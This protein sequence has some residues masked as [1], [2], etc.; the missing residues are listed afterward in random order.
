MIID[1]SEP[2]PLPAEEAFLLVRDGLPTLVPYLYDIEKIEVIERT[3]TDGKV[4]LV[5][6]WQGNNNKV[7]GPVRKFISKDLLCWKDHA[8]WTNAERKANWRIVPSVAGNVFLCTGT[9]QLV[10]D[11]AASRLIMHMDLQ[12]HPERVPGVPKFLARKFHSQIEQA[13]AKQ[14]TPNLRNLANSIR[15]YVDARD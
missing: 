4:L 15:A 2:L 6:L 12:I 8:D 7:P 1:V 3:E 13:I 5:N 10:E 9:T 11:G 14:I